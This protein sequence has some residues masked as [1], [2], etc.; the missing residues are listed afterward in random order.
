MAKMPSAFLADAECTS[1]REDAAFSLLPSAKMP[2]AFLEDAACSLLPSSKTLLS[3]AGRVE[4]QLNGSRTQGGFELDS[5]PA[6][7]P[8]KSLFLMMD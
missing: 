3:I 6:R 8:V 4:P 7:N 2:S 5:N 1:R